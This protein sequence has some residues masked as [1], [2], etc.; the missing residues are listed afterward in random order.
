VKT[1]W[2]RNHTEIHGKKINYRKDAETAETAEKNI[3]FL[4]ILGGN[5]SGIDYRLS[6]AALQTNPGLLSD[7]IIL[8][9]ST[10]VVFG[11]VIFPC[12]SV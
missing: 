9:L 1:G 4:K 7:R 12:D 3:N 8:L 11:V 10:P 2:P 6:E 5:L